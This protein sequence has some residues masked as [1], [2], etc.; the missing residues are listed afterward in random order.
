MFWKKERKTIGSSP[1][2]LDKV[3]YEIIGKEWDKVPH[4]GGVH[5]VKYLA[6]MRPRQGEGDTYDVRIYDEWAAEK[7][8]LKTIT[9]DTFDE[10]PDLILFEGWYARKAKK[11]DIRYTKAMQAA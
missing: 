9:Y 2:K 6:V 7:Y 4:D 11:G 10:H 8:R 3:L 5:W 1:M